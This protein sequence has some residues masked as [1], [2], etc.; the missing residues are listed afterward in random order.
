MK[1]FNY[2][3]IFLF[4]TGCSTT[5][6]YTS[7]G[8][9]PVFINSKSSHPVKFEMRE[10]LDFYLFGHY[11]KIYKV[12]LDDL[13]SKYGY[14]SISGLEIREYQNVGDTIL[15]VLSLGLYLPRTVIITGLAKQ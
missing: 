9:V 11:P 2:F 13:A 7:D 6:E 5:I 10:K 15:S 1:L 8:K 3:I 4:I 12:K 14:F